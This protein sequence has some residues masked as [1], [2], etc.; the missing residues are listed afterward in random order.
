MKLNDKII[1]DLTGGL[2]LNTSDLVMPDNQLKDSLNLDFDEAGKLKRRRGIFQ[3]G[4]TKSGIID[5]SFAYTR[6]SGSELYTKQVIIDR[7]ANATLYEVVHTYTTAAIT[8]VSTT[9]NVGVTTG[10]AGSGT[11]EI[12]GDLIAYTGSGA[13]SF[14]TA[15]GIRVAHPAFSAVHQ[16]ISIGATGVDT[17]SGAYFTGLNNLLFING[18][19][20]S[21][22]YDGA[23]ITPVADADEP[24]GI[25][26]TTFRDRVYVAHSGA[27]GNQK[28]VAFSDAGDSTSW[29]ATDF[30]DVEDDKGEA[31]SGL[32]VGDDILIIFKNNS[33][34]TYDEVQLKQ[35]IVGV[36]AYNHKV[37]Q[38]INDIIYTF[39]PSGVW[40]T[41]GFSAQKISEEVDDY[42][43]NFRP[44]Y[45][46]QSRVMNNCFAGQYRDKYYLYIGD[47]TT[48]ETRSDVVLIYDT[49]KK[50]W[51]VQDGYTNFAHFGSF[52]TWARGSYSITGGASAQH[53]QAL[54]AGDTGGKYWKL[55]DNKFLDSQNPR[56]V[57]GG[58]VF[59]NLVS[60]NAG[61]AIQTTAE[62]KFYNI[63]DEPT[64]L[65]RVRKI[66]ALVEQGTFQISYRLDKGDHI[67][68]W[69]SLGDFKATIT[70]C[71]LKEHQNQ[72]YRIA[73]KITSNTA[74]ITTIFNGIILK[75]RETL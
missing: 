64:Q 2:V 21:A 17:T 19:A 10:F 30:F 52:D 26:A 28:R 56:T 44:Q 66:T 9:I 11:I 73:F 55:F 33:I 3:F 41:N 42:L 51:T 13:T 67:T 32:K 8:P 36:G 23:N 6:R 25:F 59:P 16:I 18:R 14:T 29:V 47:I 39:C 43:R 70:E 61:T 22:T 15:S 50:N 35:R 1:L 37:I 49:I 71:K 75:E 57:R 12:N 46:T 4:D 74:D 24:S 27:G 62:T 20:G 65:A 48:P 38:K 68:D 45:D 34:F 69:I 5:E 72:G 54:F 58:D 7:A 63:G 31:V 53:G 40:V 60:N